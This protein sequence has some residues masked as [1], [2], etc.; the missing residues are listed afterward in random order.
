MTSGNDQPRD[1]WIEWSGGECPVGRHAI[2]QTI[3]RCEDKESFDP[4]A[5]QA[6]RYQWDHDGLGYDIV[7][8]RIVQS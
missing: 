8:Y 6:G 7:A 1:D 5:G 4:E 3:F 2:I